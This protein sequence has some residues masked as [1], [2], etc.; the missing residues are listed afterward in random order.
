MSNDEIGEKLHDM[1]T[2]GKTLSPKEQKLLE[3]WYDD[4][5]RVESELL[6]S[7]AEAETLLQKQIDSVLIRIGDTNEEIRK[8]M[9]ENK[10][11]KK[12]N[13]ELR[14]QLSQKMT[15]HAI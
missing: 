15:A 5:D 3:A 14:Q 8:I 13:A 12:E 7:G 1:A 10:S 9:N 4:Q 11:L 2:R 6:S